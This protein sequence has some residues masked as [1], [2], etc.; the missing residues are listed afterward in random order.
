MLSGVGHFSRF[1]IFYCSNK[2]PNRLISLYILADCAMSVGDMSMVWES[3]LNGI[4]LEVLIG[5]RC[6]SFTVSSVVHQLRLLS[7][8]FIGF[9]LDF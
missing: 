4:I 8:L 1:L 7:S 9:S 3:M 5:S 6:P 2:L